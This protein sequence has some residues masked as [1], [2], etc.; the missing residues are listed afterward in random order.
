MFRNEIPKILKVS[1]PPTP[2]R[3]AEN[4]PP[5][6]KKRK[7]LPRTHKTGALPRTE[8]RPFGSRL[9]GCCC[10]RFP[11][12]V[13]EKGVPFTK[14]SVKRRVNEQRLADKEGEKKR[15]RERR[16]GFRLARVDKPRKTSSGSCVYRR[17]LTA[18]SRW[19]AKD[20]SFWRAYNILSLFFFLPFLHSDFVW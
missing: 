2:L 15:E 11:P 17:I 3:S 13:H 9:K 5:P 16:N 1:F 6:K 4:P 7:W 14:W 8:D 12:R 19:D 10:S 20:P 18:E